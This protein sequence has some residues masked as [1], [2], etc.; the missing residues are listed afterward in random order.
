MPLNCL[1]LVNLGGLSAPLIAIHMILS[2]VS[3]N[4]S[5]VIF[6]HAFLFASFL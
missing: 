3:S 6:L 4:L 2:F 1:C 5:Q